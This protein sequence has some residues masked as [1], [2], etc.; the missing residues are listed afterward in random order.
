M[1][2]L[3]TSTALH[4]ERDQLRE[5]NIELGSI[6][7]QVISSAR[8][9]IDGLR[10]Y[11]FQLIEEASQFKN[12]LQE[13]QED[14]SSLLY[15]LA[16]L[17]ICLLDVIELPGSDGI[18]ANAVDHWRQ[19]LLRII[20][21][22]QER[23][24]SLESL[25]K[26]EANINVSRKTEIV[27]LWDRISALTKDLSTVRQET[28]V[29]K[30]SPVVEGLSTAISKAEI[31]W[32]GELQAVEEHL[33]RMNR[34]CEEKLLLLHRKESSRASVALLEEGGSGVE[35]DL[36]ECK[37]SLKKVECLRRE[38][39]RRWLQ[40]YH[41]AQNDLEKAK[42]SAEEHE[43]TMRSL[44]AE[45][46]RLLQLFSKT[47]SRLKT[48]G[49]ASRKEHHVGTTIDESEDSV[50]LDD[51]QTDNT[52]KE[53]PVPKSSHTVSDLR[54]TEHVVALVGVIEWLEEELISY[55]SYRT[56]ST[57]R[58]KKIMPRYHLMLRK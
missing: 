51:L 4:Q 21:E 53:R 54:K 31:R 23:V 6:L 35:K 10:E 14:H 57:T 15:S 32:S 56:R 41:D 39:N 37:A 5:Q 50:Q 18:N 40:V 44:K 45:N 20:A 19:P 28:L 2:V 47:S 52:F 3:D 36:K 16:Q 34:I 7:Q 17:R 9:R 27:T 11:Q 24:A 38:D 49:Q 33:Q 29:Q 48:S 43:Q 1:Y 12:L 58:S 22:A 25:L 42:K 26:A 46:E 13:N 30:I 55:V 8:R